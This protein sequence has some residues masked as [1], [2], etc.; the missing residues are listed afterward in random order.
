MRRFALTLILTALSTPGFAARPE[1]IIDM[2][3]HAAGA[4][5]V[6]LPGQYVCAPYDY[7]PTR[8]PREPIGVYSKDLTGSPDCRQRFKGPNTDAELRDGSLEIL[9]KR[10]VFAVTSGSA[11]RVQEWRLKA[12]DRIIPALLFGAGK[13][14][15]VAELRLL[16]AA[17]RLQVI[18]EIAAQHAGI[19]P[20]SPELEP[21]YA[22][23]EELDIPLGIHLGTGVPGGIYSATP[24]FRMAHS[25]AL[26]LEEV[27]ARHPRLRLYVMHAGWPLAEQM[28]ALLYAHPQVYVDTAAIG[29]MFPRADYHAYL[30]RLV[31]AGFEKRIM[32][33]SD[34]LV[35][36]EAIEAA[37]DAIES[38]AFLSPR[39]KRNILYE[40]A[41]RFLRLS[42]EQMALH[43]K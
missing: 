8:D 30:K 23:A 10:N 2:H 29:Y 35:W 16:H 38:A 42:P 40:N 28:I 24:K 37:I 31:D 36:P 17:G 43:R 34:Q 32:F 25:N 13:L 27:L 41:V 19:P 6:G 11:D 5:G 18:G 1:P 15:T 4:N 7:W 20:D 21:Y 12:P 9:R 39:Q 33:G 22:L 3:L 14:P 26:L